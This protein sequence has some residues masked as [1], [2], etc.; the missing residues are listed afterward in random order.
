MQLSLAEFNAVAADRAAA[1]LLDCCSSAGWAQELAA[2]RPYAAVGDVVARSD[3]AVRILSDADL[4]AALRGHARIGER[5][6]AGTPH[7]TSPGSSPQEP[8]GARWSRSEQAG[9]DGSDLAL[10]QSLAAANAEY[11]RQF[12]HIYLVCATGR[13]GP[14]LLALLRE[15]L[16]HGAAAEQAVVRGELAK[17]NQI[18]L[19][20]LFGEAG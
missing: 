14:Q 16:T 4:A 10:L 15:R 20:R 8:G 7:V 9:V 2:G 5:D 3:A 18:R 13:S 1:I 6:P 19:R 17:I 11:E 12:G